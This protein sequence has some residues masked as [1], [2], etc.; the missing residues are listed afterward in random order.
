MKYVIHRLVTP[1]SLVRTEMVG[2]NKFSTSRI[3]L[4]VLNI[5]DIESTHNSFNEA[6]EE[7]TKHSKG[8]KGMN[9]TIIPI[10]QVDL[11]GDIR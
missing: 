11:D 1:K 8:L 6:T 5:N 4:E 10:I 9:L 3:V 7:I 2:L